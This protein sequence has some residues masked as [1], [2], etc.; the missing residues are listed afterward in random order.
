[1]PALS[2]S[3]DGKHVATVSTDGL[4]SLS[5]GAR[6][7]FVDEEIADL[8]VSGGSY[9]EGGES[10]YLTWVSEVHLRPG[11]VVIVSLL[12]SASSTLDGRT[13]AEMFPDEPPSTQTDFKPTAEMYRELRARPKFREKYAFRLESSLGTKFAGETEPGEHGFGFSVHWNSFHPE[14]ARVSLHSYSLESLETRGPMSNHVEER[15]YYGNSVRFEL[16]A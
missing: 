8:D 14:R 6:G 1:M 16:V 4:D 11:Q 3:V 2:V 10:T 15:I 12:E 7:T 5:V 13:I 9:P